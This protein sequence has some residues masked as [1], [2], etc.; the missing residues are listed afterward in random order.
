LTS[1]KSPEAT[2][3]PHHEGE[4]KTFAFLLK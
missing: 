3:Q 1:Q 2:L 4:M